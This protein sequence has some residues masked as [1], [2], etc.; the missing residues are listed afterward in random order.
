MPPARAP[1]ELTRSPDS[2]PDESLPGYR[3]R[4]NIAP[5]EYRSQQNT[6]DAAYGQPSGPARHFAAPPVSTEA[7]SGRP[8]EEKKKQKKKT[9][10]QRTDIGRDLR[11]NPRPRED[12]A[13]RDQ[14]DMAGYAPQAVYGS[15]GGQYGGQGPP[16]GGRPGGSQQDY[17]SRQG[18]SGNNY[19]MPST[20]GYTQ[21]MTNNMDPQPPS[22]TEYV[23][24]MF[25][26]REKT[27]S[28]LAARIVASKDKVCT[29]PYKAAVF[30]TSV[31]LG[32]W[33]IAII[34]TS[35][36]CEFPSSCRTLRVA[37]VPLLVPNQVNPEQ[38]PRRSTGL[39]TPG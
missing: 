6:S 7:R 36:L 1:R 10:A 3:S 39:G 8:K 14:T 30:M 11:D 32:F 15:S 38:S 35:L 18:N 29:S 34:A 5:P 9:S 27:R 31:M 4:Q 20:T 2:Y 28:T 24:A 22:H 26:D 19:S 17:Q 37:R 16:G 12:I 23:K 33:V 13:S 25:A 21:G